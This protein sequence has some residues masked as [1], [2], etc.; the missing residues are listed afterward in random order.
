MRKK[1]VLFH[2][3]YAGIATGF[4]GFMRELLSYL[5]K[6]DKYEIYL[7]AAGLPWDNPDFIR[8]PWKTYGCLPNNP[9]EMEIINRDPNTARNAAYGAYYID[10]V[11]DVVKPDVYI[12]VEDFWGMSYSIDKHWFD[13]INSVI[14]WTADSVP[15]LQEAIDKA[16]KIKH[17]YVWADFAKNEF[18]RLGFTNVK[19][20]R[21]SVDT[22][23]YKRLTNLQRLELRK[24][25]NIPEDTFCVGFL[26]RN[27]LRKL[28][29][30]LIEGF[31][32]F[33]DQNPQINTKLLLFTHF[34]EGWDV[35][36]LIKEFGLKNEDILCCYKCRMTGEYFVMPFT[37]QDIN[38]PKIS[39]Q[40]T[41]I[42]V[43]VQDK[44][45]NQQ[46]NE[47][48]NLL[49]VFCL[50]ITSGGQE[51]GVQEAKLT[52]I[53]T[54][55]NPYSCGEDNC[56]PQAGSLPL[57]YSTYREI[58]TQFIKA[59]VYPSSVAKQL[60]K[61]YDMP[62]E[63]RREIGKQARK[64]V[65]ENFSIEVIGKQYEE[66]IDAMPDHNFDFKVPQAVIKNPTA[67][68]QNIENNRDWIKSLYNNILCCEP[69]PNGWSYWENLILKGSK[70]D[71]IERTFRS[72]AAADNQKINQTQQNSLDDLLDKNDKKRFLIVAKESIGD[73]LYSTAL[74]ESFKKSYPDY[75]LY[76]ACDPQYSEIFD[77]N[78]EIFRIIPYHS[79][80][81]N[82]IAMV[83]C[84]NNKGLFDG[85]CHL[86][87]NS[88]RVLNYLT[89]NNIA[90]KLE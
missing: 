39:H 46:L 66:I 31:K 28:I 84:G 43:N 29:P 85:Y 16:P 26:S 48:Y 76:L 1:K 40:K 34:S 9:Q 17:H 36:R 72:I 41:M 37:G 75:D 18:H 51:R 35:V 19:T 87:A 90:L 32:I 4:G 61:V 27:Q 12:A 80:M 3:N 58:G 74:L 57:E 62:I 64:W 65:L 24:N 25:H 86:F 30:N 10:R 23:T 50:P 52:E 7:Y 68:I 63:K 77:G 59:S 15:L 89:N 13:K 60:K 21:G 78:P 49:D 11:I 6:L 79:S 22:N 67:I 82:E 73:L 20:L 56:H 14:C 55:I 8:F 45:T 33:K 53:I 54:L 44:I 2:S 88:Q 47:W 69:D 71:E 70:R 83:G 5:Y 42:T 81:E 38:N